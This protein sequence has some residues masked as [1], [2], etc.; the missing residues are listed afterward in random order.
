M[1]HPFHAS[2]EDLTPNGASG[3][4]TTL[5]VRGEGS[6]T[7]QRHNLTGMDQT[8]IRLSTD[9]IALKPGASFIATAANGEAAYATI[10]SANF[11]KLDAPQGTLKPSSA[12]ALLPQAGDDQNTTGQVT[13]YTADGNPAAQLEV[14][15]P[16]AP[17]TGTLEVDINGVH[18]PMQS[19]LETTA[20]FTLSNPSTVP[21]PYTIT[22]VQPNGQVVPFTFSPESGTLAPGATQ[23]ITLKLAASVL[24]L[25]AFE[26][27][28]VVQ[29]NETSSETVI[30][31][32]LPTGQPG[33]KLSESVTIIPLSPYQGQPVP[34]A[35]FH[36]AARFS[37]LDACGSPI[38]TGKLTVNDGSKQSLILP[39]FTGAWSADW[40]PAIGSQ[41]W[42]L[43]L[44]WTDGTR[45]AQLRITGP[46]VQ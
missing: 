32:K 13:F 15:R 5:V 42:T 23:V 19:S 37:I 26:I 36:R 33:C 30:V 40:S 3:L 38:N 35:A 9:R 44:H 20:Q 12:I 18:F 25:S 43:D 28:L 4:E 21:V 39:N 10:Q 17:T 24:G 11:F 6:A 34:A 2:I 41:D 1:D 27:P 31:K 7:E 8:K 46:T 45:S 14:V 22:R 16:T 29:Y